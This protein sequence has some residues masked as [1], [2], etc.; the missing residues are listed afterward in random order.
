VV[1][2]R[3]QG[4]EET[5][6]FRGGIICI[7]NRELHDEELLGGFKSRV[8]VL[9]YDPPDAQ[10]GALMLGLAE[11]GWPSDRPTVPPAECQ[12]V[13]RFVIAELLRRGRSFDLRTFLDKALPDFQQW[14]EGE[15]ESDW[16]DLVAASI[17]EHL[18]AVR[19]PDGRQ[20]RA[21]R[22][23][24]EHAILREILR[25]HA[26]RDELVGVWAER[27]GKSERAFY[28]RRAEIQ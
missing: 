8:H 24:D 21:G 20:S 26:T 25:E 16:Q 14:K 4:H 13:A 2:Y 12:E 22:K 19:H 10:I 7:S 23:E 18:A 9:N 15:A 5:A 1:K 11:M 17:E 6:V 3:R 27:T 28:R